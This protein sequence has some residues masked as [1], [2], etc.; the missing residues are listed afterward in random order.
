MLRKR[1]KSQDVAT[2]AAFHRQAFSFPPLRR[3]ENLCLPPGNQK[4]T[5]NLEKQS[6]DFHS[7]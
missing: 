7:I 5:F 2:L 1:T 3:S 4:E 6:V